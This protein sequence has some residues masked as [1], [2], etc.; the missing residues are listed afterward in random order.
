M[1]GARLP[2]FAAQHWCKSRGDGI[3]AYQ[4]T[5]DSK[6]LVL[7]LS[8]YSTGDCGKDTGHTEAYIVEGDTGEVRD[9]WGDKTLTAYMHSHPEN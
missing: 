5:P 6:Q 7:I 2:P 4:W 9:H 8:V 1:R 3:Q